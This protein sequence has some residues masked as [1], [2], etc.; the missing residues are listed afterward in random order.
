M[1]FDNH[2][3]LILVGDCISPH[4]NT[5]RRKRLSMD[6]PAFTLYNTLPQRTPVRQ[7]KGW[8]VM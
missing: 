5:I 4:A 6:C 3:D 7:I 1:V 2:V 8:H